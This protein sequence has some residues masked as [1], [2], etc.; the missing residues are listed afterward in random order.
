V[1]SGLTLSPTKMSRHHSQMGMK[2]GAVPFTFY[3][4]VRG[5]VKPGTPVSVA[6]GSIN[7]EP[8]TAQ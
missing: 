3:P 8:I 6:F 4:N 5:A 7:V 2:R 1:D